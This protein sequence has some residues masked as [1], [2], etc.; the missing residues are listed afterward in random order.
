M[1]RVFALLFA[2]P[3]MFGEMHTVFECARYIHRF[4]ISIIF[5]LV[6]PSGVAKKN[7]Q[8]QGQQQ[9]ANPVYRQEGKAENNPLIFISKS[10]CVLSW[11]DSRFFAPDKCIPTA[12]TYFFRKTVFFICKSRQ[13]TKRSKNNQILKI[14]YFYI[15]IIFLIPNYFKLYG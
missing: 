2:I 15:K 14:L 1:I 13:A 11:R 4:I 10:L 7:S 5:G 6:S 8:W 3:E 12:S 9:G